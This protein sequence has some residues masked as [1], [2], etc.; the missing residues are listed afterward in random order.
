[1]SLLTQFYGGGGIGS[2]YNFTGNFTSPNTNQINHTHSLAEDAYT[3]PLW[4]G[5][6]GTLPSYFSMQSN[7]GSTT[8]SG[9]SSTSNFN[10]TIT[11]NSITITI[12]SL[13]QSPSGTIQILY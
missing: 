12:D 8:A 10:A 4:I 3:V 9:D 6:C 11:N 7:G 5:S 13:T 2:V 1:M